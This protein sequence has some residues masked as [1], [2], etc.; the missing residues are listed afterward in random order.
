MAATFASV[1]LGQPEIASMVF[2][3]QFGVYEDVRPAFCACNELIEFVASRHVYVCDS[4]F[5][6]AFAPNA[7]W[8]DDLG[9]ITPMKYALR[10]NQFDP[11]LPLHL[12]VAGG[13]T[14]LTKRILGCRP[15]LASEAIVV[16][17]FWT[18]HLEIAELLL[19]ARETMPEL[20]HRGIGQS[21]A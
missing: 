19:H 5:R 13:F 9:Y 20:S 15:E 14:Q 4:S 2:K 21:K 3:F 6:Q 11:R 10:G 1:V 17:A 8:P 16:L 7:E 18:D 12:A